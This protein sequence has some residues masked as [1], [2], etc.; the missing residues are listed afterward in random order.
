MLPALFLDRQAAEA[1]SVPARACRAHGQGGRAPHGVDLEDARVVVPAQVG[2]LLVVLRRRA[3]ADL[4]RSHRGGPFG[5]C[6]CCQ[7]NSR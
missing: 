4:D 3:E 1:Q 2:Q 7:P 6:C 5:C